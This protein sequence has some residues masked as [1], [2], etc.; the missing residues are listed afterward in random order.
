MCLIFLPQDVIN[1]THE[2]KSLKEKVSSASALLDSAYPHL[3]NHTGM[4]TFEYLE[5]VARTRH[6]L[7]IA[8][9]VLHEDTCNDVPTNPSFLAAVKNVCSNKHINRISENEAIGPNVFL[10]KVLGRT[11]SM[12]SL[13]K[14]AKKHNW[15]LPQLLR[16]EVCIVYTYTW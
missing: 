16:N 1:A 2:H 6:G 13:K 4:V 7:L 8:G 9:E 15:L 14:V 5:A 10:L 3:V 11:Y 12:S